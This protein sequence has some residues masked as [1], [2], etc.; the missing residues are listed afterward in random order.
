MRSSFSYSLAL[1]IAA[2]GL[3]LA[4]GRPALAAPAAARPASRIVIDTPMPAP[5]WALAER[6]LLAENARGVKAFE[7][8]FVD[9]NAHLRGPEHYGIADGPDDAVEPIRNWPL[10]HALGGPD[11]IIES[12]S[13]V[14]E[15]HLD[16]YS[17]AKVPEIPAAKDGIYYREFQPQYDWEH[18]SEGLAGFY[19]YGLSRPD[20]PRYAERLRRFSGFYTG[21]DP[22]APNYDRQHKIIRSL[23]N[24]SKGPRLADMSVDDWDGPLLPGHDPKRRTRFA[25]SGNVRGDHPLNLNAANLAFHA[26][27]VTG[28]RKYRDWTL[29]YVD[30]WRE[31]IAANGGNIP[32]NIGLDGTIGGEW[33]GKWYGGVFGWNSP[34]EGV[35]NY[36]FRG[37]PEAFGAAFLLTGDPRYP[38]VIRGQLDN[39][40]KAGRRVNGR[41]QVPHYFGDQGWYGHVDV[42]GRSPGLG[43]RRRVEQDVWLWELKPQDLARLPRTGWVGF[44][45]GADPDYPLKALQADLE[46]VR[47]AGRAIRED[48]TTMDFPVGITRWEN[49]NP[50]ATTALINLTMGAPDPGG[51]GHGPMPIHAQLRYFDPVE[52]RAG[53][54]EDVAALVSRIEPQRVTFTLVNTSML[55]PRIVTVQTG[56]YGEHQ[57]LALRIGDGPERPIGANHFEVRLEPGAGATLSVALRRHANQPSLAFPWN[58]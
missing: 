47:V 41:L 24:G 13:R 39:L 17:R 4:A 44:L 16:Q 37:P 43:N 35:R 25:K 1:S 46:E 36:V 28:D 30:A 22:S 21:E 56:G 55:Q 42:D 49:A 26:F 3:A 20:D 57:A 29:E 45:Q 10:A 15:G 19:F 33:G 9:G 54:P 50:V 12:W 14:W 8:A 32:S 7:A 27:L 34:D 2:A 18:L 31:R 52:R 38:A 53:L 11:S 48:K 23:I 58:R 5:A 6:K 40:Y 51:S